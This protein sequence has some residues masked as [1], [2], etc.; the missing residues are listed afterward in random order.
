MKSGMERE[1]RT[2]N[3]LFLIAFSSLI[4]FYTLLML[5]LHES[6]HERL[7]SSE[8]A[9]AYVISQLQNVTILNVCIAIAVTTLISGILCLYYLG[10][11]RVLYVFHKYRYWIAVG[12]F[13][14][15]VVLEINNTSMYQWAEFAQL[16][17]V[18]NDAPFWGVTRSIRMD[19]WCVWSPMA[20][21]QQ[22]QG[23]PAI[24]NLI[25]GGDV[26]TEWISMGGIPA[27]SLAAIFKPFYWGFL[28][29]GTSRGF[30]FLFACR[31]ILLFLVSYK[32][33]EKYT[34]RNYALSYA[35][36][37]MITLSP[38]VQWWFSQSVAEVLVFGQGMVLAFCGFVEEKTTWKKTLLAVCFAW[39]LGCFVMVCYPSWLI[40]MA[41]LIIPVCFWITKQEKVRFR[42]IIQIGI[43]VLG[44]LLLLGIIAYNSKD[45][46][47]N[48]LNSKYPGGRL[49]TGGNLGDKQIADLYSVFLPFMKRFLA[50]ESESATWI[51][52]IPA[53]IVI[54][55]CNMIKARKAD[56]LSCVILGVEFVHVV[57]AVIG[58]PAWLAKITLFSQINRPELTIGICDTVLL[59]RGLSQQE[60]AF[61][62]LTAVMMAFSF[63][64]IHICYVSSKQ[65]MD[66]AVMAV[67][68]GIYM[69]V[70]LAVFSSSVRRRASIRFTASA[71]MIV[72]LLGGGFVNPLQQGMEW[73]DKLEIVRDLQ[74]TGE[75]GDLWYVE[76]AYPATNLPL[77]AGKRVFDS[78][79][80]YPETEKW[81]TIDP[82]REYEDIYNRFANVTA[83]LTEEQTRFDLIAG[84]H[85]S[86][87]LNFKDLKTLGV[88]YVIS[89]LDYSECDVP[90]QQ[91]KRTDG[92][93]IYKVL[94]EEK[95]EERE[96]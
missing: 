84:D 56:G 88:E 13:L 36:A 61:S 92:Y 8:N 39:S 29:L 7:T 83:S 4:G 15:I 23:Y 65:V 31:L 82:S 72:A 20:I 30:S 70:Y 57:F 87:M 26:T 77:M 19:E 79:Q 11:N 54:T 2:G 49:I 42:E 66:T 74:Q 21:S 46:L 44:C 94:N 67:F 18:E 69:F 59:I 10:K 37:F 81:K 35:A 17:G 33:A 24:S 6:G 14:V 90:L 62:P 41:W 5:Q 48:I 63:L 12:L 58:F 51:T 64:I 27:L 71:L 80:V 1:R 47:Q 25:A 28:V 43:P 75:P 22:S 9:A 34:K 55:I 52:F 73:I 38:Y 68:T 95:S 85:I 91:V 53:G 89:A 60:R 32:L 78:T 86:L 40:S 45:T 76:A 16:K 96:R 3:I 50:N 93:W